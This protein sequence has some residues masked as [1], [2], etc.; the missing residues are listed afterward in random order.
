MYT[1]EKFN[2]AMFIPFIIKSFNNSLELF[3]DEIEQII[4]V[5]FLK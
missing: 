2:L 4:P 5:Y 1:C 3:T